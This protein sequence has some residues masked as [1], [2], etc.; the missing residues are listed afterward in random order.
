MPNPNQNNLF[1]E[2]LFALLFVSYSFTALANDSTSILKKITVHIFDENNKLTAVRIRVTGPDSV[3]YAPEGHSVDF[4]I[5]E[6]GGDVGQG[7]DVI[8]DN[9]RRFAYV[10]GTFNIDLPENQVIKFEVVKA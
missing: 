5:T 9:N 10:D 2:V 7:G 3:Y 6:R 8:L 4:P 1:K